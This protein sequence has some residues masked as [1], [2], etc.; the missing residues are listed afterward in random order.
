MTEIFSIFGAYDFVVRDGIVLSLVALSLY[1]VL[2]AGIFA[3]PQVGLMA[4][5]AYVSA[6][7]SV[8]AGAPFVISLLGGT[9]ASGVVALLLAGLLHRLNGIYLAI[10]SIAF[11]EVVRVAVLNLPLTGGAQ[12]KVGIPRTTT[13]LV[14]CIVVVVAVVS[15]VAL[16]RSRFGL[17]IGAM[18]EDTLMASHQGI[19]V[20]RYRTALF[21]LSGI[22]AG[23]AGSLHVHMSGFVEPGQFSFELLTQILA[24]VV[25]GGTVVVAGS[26]V[27][28]LVIIGLP[29]ALTGL[30]SYEALV[31]GVLIVL[32]VAFAPSG[33]LGC[34][35]SL[36]PARSPSAE[37]SG[38]KTT[39]ERVFPPERR[40]GPADVVLEVRDVVMSFGGLRAL[41]TVSLEARSGEVLGIIGPNGS[42]KTT[43]LNVLSGVYRPD[44]GAGTLLAQDFSKLWGLPHFTAQ[45]GLARTFQNIRLM[46]EDTVSTN[47]RLGIARHP[48]V[49]VHE[50][51][52]R[53]LTEHRLDWAADI[54]VGSL[55]YGV[56]R[57]VEIARALARE[58]HVLLL[59]EPTAGMNPAERQDVFDI[60]SDIRSGGVAVIV[61][62]HDVAM[63]RSFC[64]RLVVLD[65]GKKIADGKPDTVLDSKEVIRAYIGSGS[66]A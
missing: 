16:K 35:R 64:D 46:D 12:G 66:L 33:I 32:I 41:D 50:R 38:D 47:V 56:R 26:L 2:S 22:L 62:E 10:A 61:V 29:V 30:A 40:D 43:L 52:R 4:V 55:P 19:D 53:L 14:I 18:R 39:V 49:D 8:D 58:P 37:G 5:G 3:V 57:R 9:L 11:A 59:D 31:N 20:V 44:K 42:G 21:G 45:S 7:L 24:M 28:A 27:G 15:L 36:W 63:M 13:D 65:F 60:I 17:A 54:Q 25:I 51:T 6:V 1:V 23:A 34:L 48:G